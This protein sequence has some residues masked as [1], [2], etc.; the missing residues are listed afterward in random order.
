LALL[1]DPLRYGGPVESV[2]GEPACEPEPAKPRRTH[3]GEQIPSL[4]VFELAEIRDRERQRPLPFRIAD[5]ESLRPETGQTLEAAL[6]D[7]G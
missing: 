3:R 7:C 4:T 1:L 5:L 6:A 2:V